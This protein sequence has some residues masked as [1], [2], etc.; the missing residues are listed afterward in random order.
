MQVTIGR[1]RNHR[2]SSVRTRPCELSR[3]MGL[4][5]AISV[6]LPI[7]WGL[8]GRVAL[9]E[10]REERVVGDMDEAVAIATQPVRSET[11]ASVDFAAVDSRK[12]SRAEREKEA[13]RL[14]PVALPTPAEIYSTAPR[15]AGD[16]RAD[17][18][19]TA[20]RALN[21]Q[22][23]PGETLGGAPRVEQPSSSAQNAASPVMMAQADS[24]A[25]RPADFPADEADDEEDDAQAVDLSAIS[26]VRVVAPQVSAAG[27]ATG[28]SSSASSSSASSSSSSRSTSERS[29]NSGNA[30]A[31][32]V[33][34]RGPYQDLADQNQP[35]SAGPRSTRPSAPPAAPA[36][37][38][39]RRRARTA[40]HSAAAQAAAS[41]VS[42]S[43]YRNAL[44]GQERYMSPSQ[45]IAS[46]ESGLSVVSESLSVIP[47]LQLQS[48]NAFGGYSS[49]GIS[50]QRNSLISVGGDYDFGASATLGYI[51]N[52]RRTNLR[53][54]Y[55]PSHS[56]RARFNE[57]NTTDHRLQLSLGQQLS[58]RWSIGTAANATNSGLESFWFEAPILS[59]VENPPTSFDDLYR[60]VEAG[61]LTDDQFASLLTGA[62][63]VEDEGGQ[64]F[65]LSR[66]LNVSASA[67]ARYAYSPRLSFTVRGSISDT[68]L[69]QDPLVG[70]RVDATGRNNLQELR[71]GSVSGSMQYEL[72][73]TS[74]LSVSHSQSQQLSSFLEN[75]TQNTALSYNQ[76]IGRSWN[77]GVSFGVGSVDFGDTRFV[78]FENDLVG[79]RSQAT[80]TA[81]GNLTYKLRAH[82][83]QVQAGRMVGDGFGL[84]SQSSIRGGAGWSWT[85]RDGLWSANASASYTRNNTPLVGIENANLIMRSMGAGL[86]RRVSS[87]T[88]LQTSYYFGE[89]DSPFRGLFV[90][91]S[92]HR[93]QASFL[94]SPAQLR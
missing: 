68:S 78:E 89:F 44:S 39:T 86:K 69:L 42:D 33:S 70:R 45:D 12:P 83:F 92:V 28:G 19:R 37:A 23:K 84:G 2:T 55:T 50:N 64:G 13:P 4:L 18:I 16:L 24:A 67:N 81:N 38:E 75:T 94:W 40:L 49:N 90:N 32:A 26:P 66:V 47:G 20:K 21:L 27:A 36:T 87:T 48:V 31:D 30:E 62:P 52:W 41:M 8:G 14:F 54:G 85:T 79:L 6:A 46:I 76:R 74:A 91:N 17:R 88:A 7:V 72:N 82:S 77:Y 15:R 60:M 63:V 22:Q 1:T 25:D 56:R 43:P 58:R 10:E 65:D 3:L 53:V 9:A 51:R 59:R 11:P 35:G 80:W 29:G 93:L 34:T 73:R 61:E 57:W 5:F 71:R